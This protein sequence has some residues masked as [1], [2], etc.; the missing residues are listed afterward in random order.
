MYY[1]SYYNIRNPS[2]SPAAAGFLVRQHDK[3]KVIVDSF[4]GFLTDA[5]QRSDVIQRSAGIHSNIYNARLGGER[6]ITFNSNNTGPN[7]K[8]N[9]TF[10]SCTR[11]W[12]ITSRSCGER[13]GCSKKSRRHCS[14]LGSRMLASGPIGQASDMTIL[15]RKG[16]IG[17][18]V[19]YITMKTAIK[20]NEG[21]LT[22]WQ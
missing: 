7:F 9:F 11:E 3:L 10:Q 22:F 4:C 20:T 19:T 16:S 13:I 15:S 14:S 5:I 6:N 1:K 17:G 2:I 21:S 18:F 8:I 12:R